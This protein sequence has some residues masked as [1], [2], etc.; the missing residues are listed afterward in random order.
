MRTC[1]AGRIQVE[2]LPPGHHALQVALARTIPAPTAFVSTSTPNTPKASP[3][4]P[5]E[6][7]EA[8]EPPSRERR[9]GA[10]MDIVMEGGA[11]ER[12]IPRKGGGTKR[13]REGLGTERGRE[14][15]SSEGGSHR[16]EACKSCDTD[17]VAIRRF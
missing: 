1:G 8:P 13:G 2:G 14:V 3:T 5:P 6:A 9:S 12:C 7:T 15:L 17:I 11:T 4:N 16:R 10:R